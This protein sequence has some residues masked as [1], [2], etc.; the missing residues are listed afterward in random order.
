[1]GTCLEPNSKF[2]YCIGAC[3]K[4]TALQPLG[5]FPRAEG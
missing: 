1:M 5:D 2:E 3:A 4:V